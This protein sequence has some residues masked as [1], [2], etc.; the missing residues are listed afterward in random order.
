[1]TWS[2]LVEKAAALLRKQLGKKTNNGF[3]MNQD[4]HTPCLILYPATI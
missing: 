1:M 2:H 4:V 3:V